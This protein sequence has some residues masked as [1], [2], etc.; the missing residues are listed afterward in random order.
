[1]FKDIDEKAFFPGL[2]ITATGDVTV[3]GASINDLSSDAYL[4]L[5]VD[6]LG[7]E[8]YCISYVYPRDSIFNQGPSEIGVVATQDDTEVEIKL[9]PGVAIE[10]P[11]YD[12]TQEGHLL[13]FTLMQY[14]TYQVD[15]C[16]FVLTSNDCRT[17]KYQ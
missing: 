4:A 7:T 2:L 17:F 15:V 1:M 9:P 11:G 8:Y 13:T 14:Q 12:V 10:Y 3:Q 5:P 6:V 16:S